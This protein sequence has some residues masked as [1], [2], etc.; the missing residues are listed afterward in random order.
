MRRGSQ[1]ASIHV[2]R[3]QLSDAILMAERLSD[4]GERLSEPA[5]IATAHAG[6]ATLRHVHA[7]FQE[8]SNY[9]IDHM[10][11][12]RDCINPQHLQAVSHEE[13]CRLRDWRRR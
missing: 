9:D 12:M 11:T 8:V 5:H 2:P 7:L 1:I 4:L 3:P 13:N 10:C 6:A